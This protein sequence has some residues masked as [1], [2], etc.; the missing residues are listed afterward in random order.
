MKKS[1]KKI[2]RIIAILGVVGLLA[3][4]GIALYMFNMPHRDIQSTEADYSLTALEVV[5]EYLADEKAANQ[6]YLSANGESKILEITGTVSRISED[7]SGQKV[8]YFVGE[9][10]KAGIRASFTH[11]T[12]SSLDDV[13]I[14][15]TIT[16]KGVIRSGASY[17]EDLEMYE[18]VILEKSDVL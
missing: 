6:K 2:I 17:D 10:D 15:Q 8:V 11:E 16:V 14:G 4:A 3:G 5:S 12:N 13:Q 18:D 7:F 9:K 1:K